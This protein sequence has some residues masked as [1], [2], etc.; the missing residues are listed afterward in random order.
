MTKVEQISNIEYLA[1]E[2]KEKVSYYRDKIME[3]L[4]EDG[5]RVMK[6]REVAAESGITP[7]TPGVESS[8]ND[9]YL[10]L[11]AFNKLHGNETKDGKLR[12][13]QILMARMKD[14]DIGYYR[15]SDEEDLVARGVLGPEYE[16]TT[17]PINRYF[18]DENN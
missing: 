8:D 7:P 18:F 3:K 16:I 2:E 12:N 9:Y 4:G 6:I 14:G 11:T 15:K 5:G 17:Y 10:F 13:S 1:K